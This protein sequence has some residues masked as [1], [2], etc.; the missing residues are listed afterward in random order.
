MIRVIYYRIYT[1]LTAWSPHLRLHITSFQMVRP[2][3]HR[4]ERTAVSSRL[5]V[6]RNQLEP[7]YTWSVGE[8]QSGLQ[9]DCN[10]SSYPPTGPVSSISLNEG[11]VQFI[12]RSWAGTRPEPNGV[13]W[14]AFEIELLRY[15]LWQWIVRQRS[16]KTQRGS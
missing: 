14:R 4:C 10:L 5:Y 1:I 2:A 16:D 7:A 8:R 6:E 11:R 9:R 15:P 12:A 13:G 3:G